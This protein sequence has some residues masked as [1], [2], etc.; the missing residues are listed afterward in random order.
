MR[1]LIV[2]AGVLGSLFGGRCRAAGHTVVML[3]RGQRFSDLSNRGLMLE[4]AITGRRTFSRV[5]VIEALGTEDPYDLV[6]VPVRRTQLPTVLPLLAANKVTPNVLFMVCNPCGP[7]EMVAALG[8]GRVLSGYAGACGVRTGQVIR[9]TQVSPLLQRTV[10]GEIDGRVTPRLRAICQTFREAGFPTAM[11]SD[12]DAWLKTHVAWVC[13]FTQALYR[14][15]GDILQL[16]AS[17]DTV[18]LMVRAIREGFQSLRVLRIPVTGPLWVRSQARLPEAILVRAWRTVLRTQMARIGM[19]EHANAAREE[20]AR[21][22]DE[23][24]SLVAVTGLPSPALDRLY[25]EAGTL[26]PNTPRST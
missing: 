17:A 23:F 25:G 9:C 19:A 3:A 2:G 4:D 21:V 22:A 6:I 12:I 26:S 8:R 16:A 10:I 24:R 1:I 15:G 18:R 11:S 13:S 20:M 7:G 14:E 5:D